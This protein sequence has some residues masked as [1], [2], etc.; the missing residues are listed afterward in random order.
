MCDM[1]PAMIHTEQRPAAQGVCAQGVCS[2]P[3]NKQCRP[4]LQRAM[5][6]HH[7]ANP[8]TQTPGCRNYGCGLVVTVLTAWLTDG[9]GTPPRSASAPDTSANQAAASIHYHVWANRSYTSIPQPCD[10]N[11]SHTHTPDDDLVDVVE[12]IPVR[13]GDTTNST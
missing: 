4:A 6:T 3:T 12:L 9:S 1:T 10:L 2:S 5:Q 7:A 8:P 11:G 13:G